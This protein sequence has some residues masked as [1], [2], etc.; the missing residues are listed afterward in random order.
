MLTLF[1][2]IQILLYFFYDNNELFC[3]EQRND[4]TKKTRAYTLPM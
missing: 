1:M 2:L 3:L 4:F